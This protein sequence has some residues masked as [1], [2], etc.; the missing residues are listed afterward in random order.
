MKRILYILA[1]AFSCMVL[2][3]SCQTKEESG[4]DITGVWHLV[5]TGD[6]VADSPDDDKLVLDVYAVFGRGNFEL[7]QRIGQSAGRY[8]Y[9]SGTYSTSGNVLT[10][11]YSDGTRL[12]GVSGEGYSISLDGSTLFLTSVFSGE[13]SEYELVEEVPSEIADSAVPPVKSADAPAPVL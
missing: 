11:R 1:A 7:Y 5:D 8:W 4:T 3:V 12:G 10:G 6:L 2:S 13:V 9:Y